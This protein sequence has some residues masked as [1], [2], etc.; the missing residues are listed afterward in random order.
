MTRL[1]AARD[2]Q[3]AMKGRVFVTRISQKY[4][5]ESERRWTDSEREQASLRASGMPE[6]FER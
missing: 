5:G 1:D 4:L 6:E 2:F 3:K